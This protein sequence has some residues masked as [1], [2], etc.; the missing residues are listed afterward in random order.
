MHVEHD[1]H[2][3][4]R[5]VACPNPLAESPL[6]SGAPQTYCRSLGSQD[7]PVRKGRDRNTDGKA[8]LPQAWT[9]TESFKR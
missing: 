2:R 3:E 5:L 4:A 8:I 1:S 7:A 9:D 6:E